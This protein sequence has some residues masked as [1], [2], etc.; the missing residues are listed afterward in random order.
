MPHI[1]PPPSSNQR[2]RPEHLTALPARCPITALHMSLCSLIGPR[3]S[4]EERVFLPRTTLPS[5][6]QPEEI[7]E[8]SSWSSRQTPCSESTQ[9]V[10]LYTKISI[11]E[12]EAVAA[13]SC[14]TM[15]KH[16]RQRLHFLPGSLNSK[17]YFTSNIHRD[18][19]RGLIHSAYFLYECL[20]T[21]ADMDSDRWKW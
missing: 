14:Y 10:M 13:I 2:T 18:I 1:G 5:T 12:P 19:H 15:G 6:A 9:A 16:S 3:P 4:A 11:Y 20:G 7:Q 8:R 17:L 21:R